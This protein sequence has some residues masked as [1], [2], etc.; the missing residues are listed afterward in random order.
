MR[1]AKQDLS[2]ENH[3]R[4]PVENLVCNSA[5]LQERIFNTD[6]TLDADEV[7]TCPM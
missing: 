4:S 6:N 1:A 5:A 7:T 3:L 2:Q